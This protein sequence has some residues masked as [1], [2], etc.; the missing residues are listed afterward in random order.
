[1]L[2]IAA[3]GLLLGWCAQ[4]TGSITGVVAAH[5]LTSILV[6]LALPRLL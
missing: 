1:V 6:F 4:R 2:A 3:I 5:A